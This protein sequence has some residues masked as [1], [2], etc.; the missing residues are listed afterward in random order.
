MNTGDVSMAWIPSF[1]FE[2]NTNEEGNPDVD[3]VLK[4][5]FIQLYEI[6]AK[7]C[8]LRLLPLVLPTTM[9]CLL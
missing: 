8:L 4:K 2:R 5:K 7:V 9:R 1:T 3:R 6:V